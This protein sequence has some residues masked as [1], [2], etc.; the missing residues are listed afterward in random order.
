MRERIHELGGR[1]AVSSDEHGTLVYAS[2]PLGAEHLS[3]LHI[4]AEQIAD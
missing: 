2:I 1:F 3:P 4:G